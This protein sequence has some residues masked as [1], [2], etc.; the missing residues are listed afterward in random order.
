MENSDPHIP[1]N[2]LPPA[3][4]P[5]V[6]SVAP[7]PV[8]KPQPKKKRKRGGA[9]PLLATVITFFLTISFSVIAEAVVTATAPGRIDAAA[10]LAV[11]C[12]VILF[13][14]IVSVIFDVISVAVAACDDTPFFSMAARK[15]RGA[16]AS[17]HLLKN[18][19][20]VCSV[21]GDIVGDVCGIVSGAAGAAVALRMISGLVQENAYVQAL[22]AILVS[23][24]I[25]ALT[26]GGKAVSKRVAM[27]H[28]VGIVQTLGK[29]LAPF[30]EKTKNKGKKP[31]E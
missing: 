3:E 30:L 4:T 28:C 19:H 6:L 15:V 2:P 18:S 24:V 23:G 16:K 17:L 22:I 7:E 25:A 26:V 20:V 8:Q 29:L 1:P 21:C 12:A 31:R 9:W 14:L 11:M 5:A 10:A 13:F 27:T